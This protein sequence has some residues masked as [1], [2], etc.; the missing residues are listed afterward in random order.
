MAQD[1]IREENDELKLIESHCKED[2]GS[3]SEYSLQFLLEYIH[4]CDKFLSQS[5][6]FVC[7]DEAR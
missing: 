5:S 1:L 7:R 6:V 4:T 2:L 3:I